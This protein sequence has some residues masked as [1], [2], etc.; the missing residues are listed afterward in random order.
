MAPEGLPVR[1][2]CGNRPCPFPWSASPEKLYYRGRHEA[3]DEQQIFLKYV[4]YLNRIC[5]QKDI[6]RLYRFFKVDQKYLGALNLAKSKIRS[7]IIDDIFRY[8][9]IL[10]GGFADVDERPGSFDSFVSIARSVTSIKVVV[11][12]DPIG[13]RD[14]ELHGDTFPNLPVL[15]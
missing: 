6:P 9:A 3:Q 7:E 4:S 5:I 1:P 8:F 15:T 2:L 14:T 11:G 13:E 12:A 10:Q